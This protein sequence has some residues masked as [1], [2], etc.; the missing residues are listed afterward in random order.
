MAAI[1]RTALVVE[2]NMLIAM[3]AEE[4]L[5]DLGYVDCHV[6]GSVRSALKLI[7]DHPIAFALLDIDLGSETSEE[8]ASTL[9]AQ[10][11]PFIFASGYNEYPELA[12]E[13]ITVPVVTKPYTAGDVAGVIEKLGL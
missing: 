9:L 12:R 3:E 6:C 5:R 7:A 1:P 13:L 8:I 11:T 10:G 2:D 4:I